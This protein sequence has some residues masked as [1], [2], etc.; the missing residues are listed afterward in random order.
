MT[1]DSFLLGLKI[2]NGVIEAQARMHDWGSHSEGPPM[3]PAWL[4]LSH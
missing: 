4:T 1:V 3:K 2:N